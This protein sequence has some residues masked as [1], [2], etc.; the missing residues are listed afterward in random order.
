[1][2]CE[3]DDDDEEEDEMEVEVEEGGGVERGKR[4]FLVCSVLS[5]VPCLC[6]AVR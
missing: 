5:F 2:N 3:D 6:S 1:M 4:S